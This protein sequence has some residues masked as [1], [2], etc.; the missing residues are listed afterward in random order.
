MQINAHEFEYA[1]KF[2]KVGADVRN[3]LEKTHTHTSR[4]LYIYYEF[5]QP[6]AGMWNY[7]RRK[8]MEFQITTFYCGCRRKMGMNAHIQRR[9]KEQLFE[10]LKLIRANILFNNVNKLMN[11][12]ECE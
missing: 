1:P 4:D 3:Q 10:R 2:V 9:E 5:I 8:Y 7:V 6:A 11:M 12:P